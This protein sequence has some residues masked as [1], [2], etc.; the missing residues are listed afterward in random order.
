MYI[1]CVRNFI[2]NELLER[3]SEFGKHEDEYRSV[4]GGRS[5]KWVERASPSKVL[6]DVKDS[7]D[8][9]FVSPL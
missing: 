4:F 2:D 3:A 7:T 8:G 5:I 6:K 9:F 1:D